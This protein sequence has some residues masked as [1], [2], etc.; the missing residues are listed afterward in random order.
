MDF[1]SSRLARTIFWFV[2]FVRCKC[3]ECAIEKLTDAVE[4][5]CC[6][7]IAQAG[8][9]LMFDGSIERI[10]CITKHDDF[11][12]MTNRS[13]LTQVAPLLR[14]RNGRGY[15]RRDGQTQNQYVWKEQVLR[16]CLIRSWNSGHIWWQFPKFVFV[17]YTMQLYKWCV[18]WIPN[19]P[20][21]LVYLRFVC[22]N[23]S[24]VP[25]SLIAKSLSNLL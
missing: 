19:S 6:R 7:E 23:W 20:R 13:V 22:S 1:A 11:S 14:D 25:A 3:E 12:A 16:S 4:Y 2:C 21:T 10:S 9:K 18:N 15:R 5:R 17:K 24:P 8:Q